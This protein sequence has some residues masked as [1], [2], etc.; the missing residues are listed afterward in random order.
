MH[1]FEDKMCNGIFVLKTSI[2]PVVVQIHPQLE[3]PW[4]F[5]SVLF[6][7]IFVLVVLQVLLPATCDRALWL[8]RSILPQLWR[9]VRLRQRLRL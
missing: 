5:C 8:F 2:L 6:L 9:G 1:L 3:G 4:T 7:T